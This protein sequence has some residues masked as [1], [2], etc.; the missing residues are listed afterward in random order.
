MKLEDRIAE[1]ERENR[2]L[3]SRLEPDRQKIWVLVCRGAMGDLSATVF[4]D[5]KDPCIELHSNSA[6]PGN[7]VIIHAS[8]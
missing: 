2:E 6:G 5:P 7:S 1:L 4:T 3:R 8:I